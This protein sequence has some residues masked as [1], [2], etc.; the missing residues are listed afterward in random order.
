MKSQKGITLI[1]LVIT[2]IVLLILAGVTIAMLTGKNGILTKATG[3]TDATGQAEA[4]EAVQ[5]ALSTILANK[6]DP[7]YTGDENTITFQNLSSIIMKDNSSAIV[8][9]DRSS[10]DANIVIKYK[11]SSTAKNAY[12]VTVDSST[13]KIK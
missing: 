8:E 11:P 3:A 13:G 4:K 1:A 2:I 5:L 10:T 12:T 6:N 7:T 9:K